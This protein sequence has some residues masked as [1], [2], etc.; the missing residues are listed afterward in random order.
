MHGV[1]RPVRQV[2]AV[3]LLALAAVWATL[4]SP[5][6]FF[7]NQILV[8]GSLGVFALLQ[9]GWR[10]L[11]VGL[12]AALTTVPPSEVNRSVSCSQRPSTRSV[13]MARKG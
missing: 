2:L 12:A 9:F 7:D 11:P 10:G 13:S 1:P 3:V 6:I 8:G 4:H 5:T